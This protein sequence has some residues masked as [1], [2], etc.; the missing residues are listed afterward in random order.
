MRWGG[1]STSNGHGCQNLNEYVRYH[2]PHPILIIKVNQSSG[3]VQYPN[4]N[5][6]LLEP[7]QFFL[8]QLLVS[9]MDDFFFAVHMTPF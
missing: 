2:I 1:S 8:D 3:D 9:P 5:A 6:V 4:G 7:A